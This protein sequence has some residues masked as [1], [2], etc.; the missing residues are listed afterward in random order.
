MGKVGSSFHQG[1]PHEC[2]HPQQNQV[3]EFK[4]FVPG[5]G[6]SVE[7]CVAEI[8]RPHE[9]VSSS[10]FTTFIN[11]AQFHASD[12]IR[13]THERLSCSAQPDSLHGSPSYKFF[14]MPARLWGS[15]MVGPKAWRGDGNQDS[16][17]RAIRCH[18]L[19]GWGFLR[20][21]AKKEHHQATSTWEDCKQLCTTWHPILS[22]VEAANVWQAS[23]TPWEQTPGG[24]R[25]TCPQSVFTRQL[26]QH[27]T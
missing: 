16:A 6:N 19:W 25:L 10:A 8:I 12:E 1:K 26:H 22:R 13:I 7:Q 2:P 15:N 11:N 20:L 9:S 24:S 3:P 27:H 14:M 4:Q 21:A 5:K 18:Q 17:P 23:G